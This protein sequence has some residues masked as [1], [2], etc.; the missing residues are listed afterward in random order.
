MNAINET[1]LKSVVGLVINAIFNSLTMNREDHSY[2]R[3][4]IGYDTLVYAV[5]TLKGIVEIIG[6]KDFYS[7][8]EFVIIN[9]HT[10][11]SK[12]LSKAENK[13]IELSEKEINS[14]YEDT[15][16]WRKM[17]GTAKLF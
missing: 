4:E 3:N 16:Q 6:T 2:P 15:E 1:T 7:M 17:V 12:L 9:M 14:L 8:E 5:N 11:L 13:Y 10:D